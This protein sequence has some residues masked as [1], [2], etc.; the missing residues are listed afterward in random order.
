[1]NSPQTDNPQ[2]AAVPGR[3]RS[4]VWTTVLLAV[5]IFVAGAAVGGGATVLVGLRRLEHALQHP[6]MMPQRITDRLT[7][8]LDL[9]PDQAARVRQI[10]TQ[11]Q[12]TFEEIRREMYPRVTAELDRARDEIAEVLTDEQ[13]AQWQR[14]FEKTR[15]RF[16][17]PPPRNAD[18]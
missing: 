10:V 7:R 16:R 3:G 13:R 9:S 14:L 18:G 15:R 17:P 5:V 2:D 8:R 11:R 6:Q 12:A 4:R 1:M